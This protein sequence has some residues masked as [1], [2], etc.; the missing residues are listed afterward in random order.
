MFNEVQSVHNNVCH[1]KCEYIKP[2]CN[3]YDSDVVARI[4]SRLHEVA[5]DCSPPGPVI[6]GD[7][8]G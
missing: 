8:V 6:V 2:L 3:V 1:A 5:E 4:L 7:D